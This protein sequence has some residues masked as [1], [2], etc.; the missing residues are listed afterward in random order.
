M[1]RCAIAFANTL[2]EVQVGHITD[3]AP[4]PP[5]CLF[6]HLSR[7]NFSSMDDA[8]LASWVA[9]CPSLTALDLY[10]VR[11]PAAAF[12][13]VAAAQLIDLQLCFESPSPSGRVLVRQLQA[14]RNLRRLNLR[15]FV[16][17]DA[18]LAA[19]P[20]S[21]VDLGQ[22]G[23]WDST[24]LAAR[25]EDARWLPDLRMVQVHKGQGPRWEFLGERLR[26]A[27]EARGLEHYVW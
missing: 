8:M 17:D 23:E 19:M 26:L 4:L 7:L 24:M 18:T 14:F 2:R 20:S 25:L 12:S 10:N 21:P 22:V 27:W 16:A 1:S 3:V 5:T 13:P 9:A 6:P 15:G 11:N